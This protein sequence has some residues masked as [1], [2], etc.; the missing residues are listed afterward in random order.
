MHYPEAR[1]LLMARA[2]VAGK[3]K[4]RLIPA[5]GTEGAAT[6]QAY[7]VERQLQQTLSADLA[8]IQLWVAGECH[9]PLFLQL[10]QRGTFT[11]HCQQGKDLGARMAHAL[12]SA[13]ET[14]PYAI[15]F[16]SDIPELDGKVLQQA[17]QALSQ[18]MDAVIVPAEDG[19]YALL[20]VRQVAPGLFEGIDWGTER[21]MA[22]TRVR[23]K[24]L[25]WRWLELA[26]L[27]DLD[28]PQDLKRFSRLND[29]PASVKRLLHVVEELHDANA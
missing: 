3:A 24:Q 26:P 9:H 8:P 16:G 29:L 19:G 11:L 15:L 1:L 12:A 21:V 25:E 10:Q 7:L 5:L 18:G 4:T 6:L 22:Q 28:R 23:L 2:P 13:L 14:A 17:C 27:W 20:G